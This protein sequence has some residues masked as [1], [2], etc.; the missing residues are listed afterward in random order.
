MLPNKN[1]QQL[2]SYVSIPHKVW[3]LSEKKDVLKLDWNEAT[4]SPSPNVFSKI[5]HYLTKEHLNWY[6]NTNNTI[7]LEKLAKY[8]N[9]KDISFVEIFASSDAAHENIIDVFLEKE[10]KICIIGPT[11]DNFRARA[12]GVGIETIY[13][14]LD[15]NFN[16][17][18]NN[19]EKFL[20]EKKIKFLYLCNPNNPTGNSYSTEM[21]KKL[22]L[23]NPYVMFLIDEA[24]YEFC[25]KSLQDL[26]CLCRNLIITR[27]FSKAFG[28]AS[29]R[30]GYVLSHT[31]NILSL[32]KL[33]NSKS[34]AMLS[35]IAAS[36]ALEDI[37]YMRTYVQEVVLA[38][39]FFYNFLADAFKNISKSGDFKF[40]P[41][42]ANFIFIKY[43]YTL[44]F[45]EFLHNHNIFIRDYSHIMKE[46]CRISIGTREQ[47]KMVSKKI[48]E[49]INIKH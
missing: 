42:E 5:S 45:C 47:M 21:I 49:F 15:E 10:D 8:T 29:F 7:L 22:I 23:N 9:Q 41:S 28:L 3:N 19:L 34:V 32:K 6:P 18:F 46:H 38:K 36:A 4:I 1:I 27:T 20:K 13:Y 39:D 44:E 12:N 33:K 16:L 14:P 11:Y 25:G 2:K 43:S 48:E 37:D 40:Y 17:D 30:I 26:V 35:Q 31:E 24:Y